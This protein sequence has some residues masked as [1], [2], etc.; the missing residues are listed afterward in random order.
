MKLIIDSSLCEPP[1]EIYP[2]RD[3]TLYAKTFVFEDVI[4]KCPDGTRSMYWNW[5]KNYGAHDFISYLIKYSELESGFQL[6][7]EGSNLNIEY[8]SNRNLSFIISSLSSINS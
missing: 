2:F 3:V 7:P 8:I 6:G 4:L 1:S 5:L